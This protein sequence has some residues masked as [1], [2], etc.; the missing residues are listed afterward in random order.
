MAE[1]QALRPL[2]AIV[3]TQFGVNVALGLGMISEHPDPV[4]KHP[5]VGGDETG[6]AGRA[7]IFGGVETKASEEPKPATDLP[8]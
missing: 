4:G 8:R 7:E 1:N 5:V 2:H 3:E 6:F